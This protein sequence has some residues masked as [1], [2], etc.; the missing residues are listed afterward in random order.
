MRLIFQLRFASLTSESIKII[1]WTSG[2]ADDCSIVIEAESLKTSVEEWDENFRLNWKLILPANWQA[3]A[4]PL[5]ETEHMKISRMASHLIQ[6][7]WWWCWLQWG[8]GQLN[9]FINLQ[10]KYWREFSADREE[11][12]HD[13]WEGKLEI[14]TTFRI[15]FYGALDIWTINSSLAISSDLLRYRKAIKLK[16]NAKIARRVTRCSSSPP[17][18]SMKHTNWCK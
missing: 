1:N 5:H 12:L 18:R 11:F 2:W 8:G 15:I 13:N 17:T 7:W 9:S 10:L 14:F 3:S 16:R 4:P 6:R